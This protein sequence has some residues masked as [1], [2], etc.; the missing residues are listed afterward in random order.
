MSNVVTPPPRRAWLAKARRQAS[1]ST[2]ALRHRSGSRM[3]FISI[4]EGLYTTRYY[5]EVSAFPCHKL[6]PNTFQLFD[7]PNTRTHCTRTREDPLYE[8][9]RYTYTKILGREPALGD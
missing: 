9:I 7:P 6:P 3:G 8:K 4:R 5:S 1:G 2:L